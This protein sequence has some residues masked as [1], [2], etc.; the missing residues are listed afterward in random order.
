[1]HLQDLRL[2]T[3]QMP[4]LKLALKYF[5]NHLTQGTRLFIIFNSGLHDLGR[6]CTHSWQGDRSEFLSIPDESFSCTKQYRNSMEEFVDLLQSL[7]PELLVFQSTTAGWPKWGNYGG[8]WPA[9]RT[10]Q[11]PEDPHGVSKNLLIIFDLVLLFRKKD[12]EERKGV[13][14]SH[15]IWFSS[16]SCFYLFFSF[17]RWATRKQCEEFNHVAFEIMQQR[18]IPVVDAYWLS[19]ARPDNR[20]ISEKNKLSKKLVHAGL[21]VYDVLIREWITLVTTSAMQKSKL[22]N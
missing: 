6:L 19:L 12:D 4:K 10:Q 8:A 18:R 7:Q 9:S 1:L 22:Q 17:L 13:V 2:I 21:E 11:Y 15:Q 5:R 20:E 14:G 3:K 16:I